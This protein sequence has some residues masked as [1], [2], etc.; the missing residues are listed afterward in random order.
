MER[1]LARFKAEMER[2]SPFPI[3][4]LSFIIMNP[5]DAISAWRQVASHA[6]SE[7]KE[8]V[9][10]VVEDAATTGSALSQ[11]SITRCAKMMLD[12]D[13]N[14]TVRDLMRSCSVFPFRRN[15]ERLYVLNGTLTVDNFHLHLKENSEYVEF[16]RMY[17]NG[18][19]TGTCDKYLA[20]SSPMCNARDWFQILHPL[21]DIM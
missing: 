2:V 4:P 15:V 14:F 20:N 1:E 13:S 12:L 10:A 11:D 8:A 18:L 6:V 9:E 3:F 5:I 7:F 17:S 19:A 16:F 21:P